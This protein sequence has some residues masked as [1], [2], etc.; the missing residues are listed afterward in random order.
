[1][2][3]LFLILFIILFFVSGSL[4]A[5]VSVGEEEIQKAILDLHTKQGPAKKNI[6]WGECGK[7]LRREKATQRSEEYAKAIVASLG[8]VQVKTNEQINPDYLVAILYRESS[9][10]ECVIGRHETNKL[11][12]SLGREPDK[13]ELLNHVRAWTDAYNPIVKQCKKRGES[14]DIGCVDKLITKEYPEYRGIYGWD[15][16]AAQYRWPGWSFRRRSVVLPSGRVIEKIRLKE[17]FDYK[18]SVHMLA[19]DLAKYKKE[20]SNHAHWL[21]SKWGRKVRKLDTEEAYF[22]HHHTGTGVW[23]ERYWKAVNRH[24]KV[25][26]KGREENLLAGVLEATEVAMSH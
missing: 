23:S 15:L 12:K 18:V 19:E 9:F 24:L 4:L 6:I 14:L 8:L 11:K 22:A 16:G 20:C 26:R 1:M 3:C 25:I 10:N 13:E 5:N 17:I 2:R 7:R 21:Y